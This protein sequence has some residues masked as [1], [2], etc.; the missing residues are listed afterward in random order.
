M[1]KI[2]ILFIL[3]CL[4]LVSYGQNLE[5]KIIDNKDEPV[6]YAQVYQKNT[7]IS[8]LTDENGL[9]NISQFDKSDWI[10]I[11][12][13]GYESTKVDFNTLASVNYIITLTP[14]EE[15]MGEVVISGNRWE[16]QAKEIPARI[17]SI[18]AS[19][20]NF[21][22]PQ[23]SA[24]LLQL[25]NHVYVQKSQLGGGSPMIRGFATNRLLL[26]V[27]GV[28]MNN[29]IFRSGNIQNVI[30]IDAQT[31]EE[32]EVLFG[33]GSV[34][35]GSD[36]IG[37]VMDFHTLSPNFSDE[38]K[39]SGLA[40]TRYSSAN[41]EMTFHADIQ[42]SSK[43]WASISSVS[44]SSFG[45]L[46]MGKN[47]PSEYLRDSF[48]TTFNSVDTT[49]VNSDPWIQKNTAF[50]Q[51]NIMQKIAYQP[52]ESN[53]LQYAF[54]YGE[55]SDIARYDR[56]TERRGGS[57]RDAEWYYGPQIWQMQQIKWANADSTTVYDHFKLNLSYQNFKESRNERRYRSDIFL[58]RSENI[59]AY[60]FTLD[61]DK[62]ISSKTDV[63]Y[64]AEYWLNTVGSVGT[65]RNLITNNTSG[66]QSRYPNSSSMSSL[67]AYALLKHKFSP[68]WIS[69]TAIR[70]S[71]I[72]IDA[73]LNSEFFNFPLERATLSKGA[74]NGSLGLVFLPLPTLKLY[75][76]LST[77]F[78]APNIDDIGK[79]FDSEPGIVIVPNAQLTPE[80]AYST[81]LGTTFSIR[82]QLK[83]DVS[84]Y[85]TY[86]D[87]ALARREFSLN[88]E[89]SILY[90][91]T[92]SK[93][94]AI[95]NIGFAE[96]FGTQ[97]SLEWKLQDFKISAAYNWQKGIETEGNEDEVVPL[98]HV[99][100]SYGNAHVY[101]SFNQWK[102]DLYTIFNGAINF[103]NLAPS[104]RNKAYIYA[105][106]INGN[107]FSP[108]WY[109][110]NLKTEY[111]WKNG[112]SFQVGIEN[113]TNQLYRPY[114]SGISAPG[115]NL[116][117]GLNWSF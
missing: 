100:P 19:E 77:G 28:R 75:G 109:T 70:Y 52:N 78:R 115:R 35:Y 89:D 4:S 102:I 60:T 103:D 47:G 83:F 74:I 101:Y 95:Q 7:N 13:V 50:S 114:S 26:V 29:A 6:A 14:A 97:I 42:L 11:R 23:T 80:Y 37:G 8:V 45:D 64:G 38:F 16:Q 24:D 68:K 3:L 5:L 99:P 94:E 10:E 65:Q 104:E 66:I 34:L 22:N 88:G 12:R 82:N 1:N 110:L 112:L 108:A 113:I 67:G 54:H 62:N 59:D 36:A 32:T 71:H 84:I 44:Y 93:V 48:Q 57:F 69:N 81:D 73:P 43:K 86:L 39:A 31:I 9:A 17:E 2:Y 55:S 63:F 25:A 27:D 117:T 41:N 87:N 107:P 15:M 105:K 96:V 18:K 49:L 46:R 85:Y 51:F 76:N 111:R 53:K 61:F 98:R 56:L 91:G 79:V 92:L 40:N 33:P 20:I 21:Q 72:N 30:S 106:D 116:I 90:D 58:N